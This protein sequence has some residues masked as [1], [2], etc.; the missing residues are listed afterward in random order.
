MAVVISFAFY[1]Q[2]SDVLQ[3]RILQQLN[4]IKTLKKNQVEKLIQS[5]WDSF[6]N[7]PNLNSSHDIE[8]PD[9]IL[10]SGI[11]DL[12]AHNKNKELTIG[13]IQAEN[14]QFRVK[15]IPYSKIMNILLERTGMGE[16]GESY[17]VGKDHRMRSQSRFFK[18]SLPYTIKVKTEGVKNA[19]SGELGKGLYNDY[20][21][22]QVYGVYGPIKISNLQLAI[23][24]EIDESEVSEP[25]ISLRKR[26]FGLMF[27]IMT[28]AIFISLF[29]TRIIANPILNMK[30]SLK[31]MTDGHYD[32]T[33]PFASNS[34]EIKEM[35]IAL[36]ELKKSLSG[37]VNFSC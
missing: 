3:S 37:S 32:E 22:I 24:S 20:R 14:D 13:L 11:Y 27:L 33:D 2:F 10:T 34:N 18:D 15:V 12:T 5:E 29:L 19:L 6:I 1:N 17:L 25:L 26:L 35:F 28:I 30:K 36:D 23:L 9:T 31:V 4:S 7:N 21:A 16:T 8:I